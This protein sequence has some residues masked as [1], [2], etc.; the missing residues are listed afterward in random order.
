VP[1][2]TI[3][4]IYVIQVRWEWQHEKIQHSTEVLLWVFDEL[5]RGHPHLH[6]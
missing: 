3:V 1:K 5:D 6:L 2:P 4:K